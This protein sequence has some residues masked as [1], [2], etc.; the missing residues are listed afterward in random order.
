MGPVAVSV[1]FVL[2]LSLV[3][4]K[5]VKN[6]PG[7][8]ADAV[9]V[10]VAVAVCC[11]RADAAG[12]PVPRRTVRTKAQRA[13]ADPGRFRSLRIQAAPSEAAPVE[14][15]LSEAAPVEAAL[16]EA[17]PVEAAPKRERRTDL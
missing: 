5:P 10:M 2:L 13:T 8:V 6:G 16:S 14:A 1:A 15:A 17:A 12:P 4:V 9:T 7:Q 3:Q 11:Q